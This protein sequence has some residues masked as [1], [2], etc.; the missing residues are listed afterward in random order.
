VDWTQDLDFVATFRS[1]PKHPH[2][3]GLRPFVP[4][5]LGPP[6]AQ[7]DKSVLHGVRGK[8]PAAAGNGKGGDK[9]AIV[10]TEEQLGAE[11]FNASDIAVHNGQLALV[12]SDNRSAL[13][14]GLLWLQADSTP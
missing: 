5:D 12:H 7:L 14:L 4:A 9:R 11:A 10:P 1:L 13:Q 3:P 2:E 8:L 6:L